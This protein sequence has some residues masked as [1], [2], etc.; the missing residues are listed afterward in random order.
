MFS[1]ALS[2]CSYSHGLDHHD[3]LRHSRWLLR[4]AHPVS[5][6]PCTNSVAA[7]ALLPTAPELI[8][9][10][11]AWLSPKG[12]SAV[13]RSTQ[14]TMSIDRPE[15][16]PA[17]VL[18]RTIPHLQGVVAAAAEAVGE[19][20]ALLAEA[21]E[22]QTPQAISTA[23][24][25]AAALLGVTAQAATDL[26]AAA[27]PALEH[28]AAQADAEERAGLELAAEVARSVA[29]AVQAA[30]TAAEQVGTGQA[31][32]A[33]ATLGAVSALVVGVKAAADGLCG[34]AGL[35]EEE[36]GRAQRQVLQQRMA[37]AK[38]QGLATGGAASGPA[39]A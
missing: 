15:T 31:E 12:R 5:K 7:R 24:A 2:S 4:A 26:Q 28:A 23:A 37:L 32:H 18:E 29:A 14:P 22:T 19:A 36:A 16:T 27:V 17:V 33:A 39:A 30:E 1:L 8:C 21:L 3:A 6:V 38:V 20:T 13:A 35:S 25:A 34:G 10:A 11:P 9:L